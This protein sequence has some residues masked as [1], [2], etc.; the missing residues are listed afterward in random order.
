[1]LGCFS[2]T[3]VTGLALKPCASGVVNK[4]HSR[5]MKRRIERGRYVSD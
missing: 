3:L 5:V 2:K 1:M 4:V